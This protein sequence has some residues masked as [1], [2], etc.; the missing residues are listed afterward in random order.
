MLGAG[1]IKFHQLSQ[2]LLVMGGGAI[3]CVKLCVMI[4]FSL[5]H[6]IMCFAK[7]LLWFC[8]P[9]IA[10]M[11]LL[12]WFSWMKEVVMCNINLKLK[13]TQGQQTITVY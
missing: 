6:N 10:Y 5:H 8:T 2:K 12:K 7:V 1:F 4:N 11:Q 3:V 9:R 13:S